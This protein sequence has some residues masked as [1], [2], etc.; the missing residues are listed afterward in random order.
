M[1]V[2]FINK[3]Q[4]L[5]EMINLGGMSLF[6]SNL[7]YVLSFNLIKEYL[8]KSCPL[9][10]GWTL[11]WLPPCVSGQF[12][13]ECYPK[14]VQTQAWKDLVLSVQQPNRQPPWW[15][16]R[17]RWRWCLP[18]SLRRRWWFWVG[19]IWVGGLWWV[20]NIFYIRYECLREVVFHP[21]GR[22]VYN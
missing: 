18:L 1:F 11:F 7:Y 10:Q 22:N 12:R 4:C 21:L 19:S 3:P 6:N 20:D 5:S 2:V 9:I 16:R 17:H 8:E 13:V 15:S 14:V